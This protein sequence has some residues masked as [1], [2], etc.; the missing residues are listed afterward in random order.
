MV[1]A[2]KLTV[3]GVVQTTIVLHVHLR[4]VPGPYVSPCLVDGAVALTSIALHCRFAFKVNV[5]RRNGIVTLIN[6]AHRIHTVTLVAVWNKLHA[7]EM[8]IA[9]QNFVLT[10]NVFKNNDYDDNNN[11]AKAYYDNNH[12]N[13]NNNNDDDDDH[14]TKTYK[15]HNNHAKTYNN[16][17]NNSKTYNYNNSKTYDTVL[18][19]RGLAK[20]EVKR[21]NGNALP[22][23]S[24]MLE[25]VYDCGIE[26]EVKEFANECTSGG[27]DE[28]QNNE[29]FAQIP[30][31]KASNPKQALYRL[32]ELIAEVISLDSKSTRKEGLVPDV[33]EDIDATMPSALESKKR[34]GRTTRVAIQ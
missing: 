12:N 22:Q 4:D 20:G 29:N 13:N 6:N 33:H 23:A 3:I 10:R 7:P 30:T 19:K 5:S 24:N 21:H 11:N 32:S 14:Q 1:A 28:W 17:H 34:D 27:S 2:V 16:N 18:S 9:R 8:T 25:A 31:S 15:N 26:Y